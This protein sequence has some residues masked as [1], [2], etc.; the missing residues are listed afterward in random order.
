[1]NAQ[2]QL[3]E[4]ERPAE[5]EPEPDEV[6]QHKMPLLDQVI[7][8]RH[9]LVVFGSVVRGFGQGKAAKGGAALCRP[10]RLNSKR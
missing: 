9:R 10:L 2:P 4:P 7:E 8:Q 5:P 3:E 1:M 6:E